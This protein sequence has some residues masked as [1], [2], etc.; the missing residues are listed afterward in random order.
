MRAC[1]L[2][3][4][5]LQV[6]VLTNKLW[7]Q[8][9][10]SLSIKAG[11][12]V[13]YSYDFGQP[14][15]QRKPEFVYSYHRNNEFNLNLGFIR[16]GWNDDRLRA[17]L[18][19]MSG[20]YAEA[21]LAQEPALF[22][23]LMEANVGIRLSKKHQLWLDAGVMPS[24]IGYESAFGPDNPT[25]TR[26]IM[27]DNSPYYE[28]GLKFSYTTRE[29]NL[30]LA[31]LALN[32]WQRI[33][34]QPGN[35]TPAFGHQLQWIPGK[36]WKLNSSSFMGSDSPDSLRKMRYFH[37]FF[38]QY[39]PSEKWMI[40]GVFDIGAQQKAKGSSDYHSWLTPALIVRFAP[41]STSCLALRVE[42]FEDPGSVIIAV[43]EGEAPFR[44][45]GIS[46]NYDRRLHKRCLFRSEV[47]WLQGDGDY[48]GRKK[49][50]INRQWT[51]TTSL[52][53]TL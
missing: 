25:L 6:F 5:L 29:Q 8:G 35:N 30:T 22:R 12:E 51:V 4:C 33:R 14:A 39:S 27:A 37:N 47:R 50:F 44:C 19:L 1:L 10:S 38:M 3:L 36:K 7:A 15:A 16:A 40:L 49:A 32:G 18:A 20:T 28:S 17:G 52:C 53:F 26:S 9:D 45:G 21:N 23:M 2:L 31:V 11:L 42:Y 13:Y 43:P 41:D 34:R 24:H 48:F 46:L